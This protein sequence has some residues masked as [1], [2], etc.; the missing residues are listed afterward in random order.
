[1]WKKENLRQSHGVDKFK[2]QRR[3]KR[4]KPEDR[5]GAPAGGLLGKRGSSQTAATKTATTHRTNT[6]TF[7]N[8]AKKR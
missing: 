6:S 2:K 8:Q 5:E 7:K 4:E 3:G 1:M